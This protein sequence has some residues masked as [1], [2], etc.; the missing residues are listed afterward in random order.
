[1]KITNRPTLLG[2]LVG[3]LA[4][5]AGIDAAAAQQTQDTTRA[6]NP[7][8]RPGQTSVPDM[9]GQGGA[10][11]TMGYSGIERQPSAKDSSKAAPAGAAQDT[12]RAAAARTG[13]GQDTSGAAKAPPMPQQGGPADTAGYT[14]FKSEMGKA[15]DSISPAGKT[16]NY[17]EKKQYPAKPSVLDS[18]APAG[19]AAAA[20]DTSAARTQNAAPTGKSKSHAKKGKKGHRRAAQADTTGAAQ[21]GAAGQTRTRPQGATRDST[22][23]SSARD[24]M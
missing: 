2:A 16:T 9:P 6:A 10:M 13:A 5:G 11:D 22:R 18:T 1:M 24:S 19:G 7:A 15:G 12:S 8:A 14:K 17:R 20:Q 3:A 4:L 21:P 23:P